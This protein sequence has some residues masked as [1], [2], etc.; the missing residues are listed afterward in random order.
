MLFDRPGKVN[1]EETLKAAAARARELG[2]SELVVATSGGDTAS[3]CGSG[4]S[5]ASRGTFR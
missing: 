5:S 1:T 4:K 2:I 3:T